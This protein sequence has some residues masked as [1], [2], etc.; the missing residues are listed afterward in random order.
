MRDSLSAATRATTID[1][2]VEELWSNTVT[3]TPIIRSA[4]GLLRITL[5]RKASPAALPGNEP[6]A[7]KVAFSYKNTPAKVLR[8]A[9]IEGARCGKSNLNLVYRF[10]GPPHALFFPLLTDISIYIVFPS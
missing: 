5:L 2:V 8:E 4:I 7:N 1:V 10:Q 3:R 6:Q 9:L